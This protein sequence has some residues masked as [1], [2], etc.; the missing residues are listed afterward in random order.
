MEAGYS[1]DTGI[2]TYLKDNNDIVISTGNDYVFMQD[3]GADGASLQRYAEG[4]LRIMLW[5]T[6]I[7]TET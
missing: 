3:N 7:S 6:G 2:W 5:S 4:Y 1:S